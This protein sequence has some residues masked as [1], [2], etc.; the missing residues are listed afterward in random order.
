MSRVLA[1]VFGFVTASLGLQRFVEMPP[2][3]GTYE[4]LICRGG[5]GSGDSSRAYIHGTLVLA[6]S[7]LRGFGRY[8]L[9]WGQPNGCFDLRQLQELGDSYAGIMKHNVIH[10]VQRGDTARFPIYR[11]PD[12]GYDL[13]LT[14]SPSGLSGW[15]NSWGAGVTEIHAPRDSVWTRRIGDSD[16]Q[17]C[18]KRR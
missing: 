12:A 5:C 18:V 9:G 10:W 3:T 14:R 16:Q 6:E 4:F 7:N 15:G 17:R 1:A 2:L 13:E 8:A 11:S